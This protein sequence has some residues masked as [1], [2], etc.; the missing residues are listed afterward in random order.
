MGNLDRRNA[1]DSVV[2]EMV[3]GLDRNPGKTLE[4]HQ[5]VSPTIDLADLGE[6]LERAA[7]V[8]AAS[9]IR[10]GEKFLRETDQTKH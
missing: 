2:A 7:R 10:I 9:S 5:I 1:E 6:R 3:G 8:G 4:E